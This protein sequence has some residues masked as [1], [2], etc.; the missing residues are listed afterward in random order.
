MR[1]EG[2]SPII[3]PEAKKPVP[4]NPAEMP[5]ETDEL[6]LEQEAEAGLVKNPL[7]E[8]ARQAAIAAARQK[9][10]ESKEE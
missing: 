7:K 8:A 5:P 10:A 1:I 9:I 3:P 6:I 4:K 2:Q